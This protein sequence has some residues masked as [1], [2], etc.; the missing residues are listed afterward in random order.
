MPNEFWCLTPREF[1]I[2][3]NGYRVREERVWE[4]TAWMVAHLMNVSGNLKKAVTVDKLLGRD[5]TA[6][7]TDDDKRSEL[8][9]IRNRFAEIERVRAERAEKKVMSDEQ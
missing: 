6:N 5:G 3:I 4:R 7:L 1:W 8:Q 2:L 9:A